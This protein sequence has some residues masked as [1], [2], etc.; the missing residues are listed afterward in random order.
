MAKD[1]LRSRLARI[2][3]GVGGVIALGLL[4]FALW[5]TRPWSP[6]SP[7]TVMA[8][9]EIEDR[10]PVYRAMGDYF[11]YRVV[12]GADAPTPLPRRPLDLDVSWTFEGV[13]K[14]LDDYAAANPLTG[15]MIVKDG[16]VV[17]ERYY[18]GETAE[19]QH[20]TWS[21]AKSFVATLVGIALHEGKLD[22]LDRTVEEFA[23]IYRGRD[24]GKVSIRH[25]L[26]MASGIDF[27][28]EEH[29]SRS[30]LQRLFFDT[31]IMNR[32][33]D[34]VVR[35]YGFDAEPGETFEYLS[36]NSAVLGAVVRGIYDDR[37][38]ADVISEKL[39]KPAGMA[40]GTWLLDRNQKRGKEL[41]YC[42]LNIRLED[43]ARFGLLYLHKGEVEGRQLF[44]A[45]WA[46]FVRTPSTD[47]HR[48]DVASARWG[49]GHH[50][51]IPPWG[52]GIFQASGFNG[53]FVIIV[54]DADAVIAIT[55]AD[56]D[57]PHRKPE[58]FEVQKALIAAAQSL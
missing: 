25:L 42:C 18:H 8:A 56:P 54:P 19:D 38:L 13:Q 57:F 12:E 22:S 44:D 58:L 28:E 55:G 52:D 37:Q 51:W 36:S 24:Y 5:L 3:A 35:G 45:T 40:S 20:T 1:F 32:D 6:Y 21:V 29:N 48:R 39:F 4:V 27:N 14:S 23:P 10:I 43:Y 31:F 11:P 47:S 9:R 7:A 53:Q 16:E 33:L 49:Y 15:A 41:T 26:A 17:F 2:L 30:D 34:K 46:D 50:F